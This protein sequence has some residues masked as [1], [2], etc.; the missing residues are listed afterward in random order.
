MTGW[1][2]VLALNF[3]M[4]IGQNDQMRAQRHMVSP[5]SGD[6]NERAPSIGKFRKRQRMF[7]SDW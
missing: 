5:R 6:T 7:L 3:K 2:F 4:E 1:A